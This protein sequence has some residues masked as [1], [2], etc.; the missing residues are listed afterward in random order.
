PGRN[1]QWKPSQDVI[2]TLVSQLVGEVPSPTHR[3]ALE[4]CAHVDTTSEGLLRAALPQ[5]EAGALFTWL[6]G[7]PFIETGRSGI[8]PHTVVREVLDADLRWRDPQRYAVMHREIL[9]HLIEQARTATS[10]TVLDSSAA[11][12]YLQRHAGFA[13]GW[14]SGKGSGE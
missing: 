11:L 5:A 8:R 13:P 12:L 14:F 3:Q 10:A 9:N 6:R 1:T 2:A 4:I 7:L